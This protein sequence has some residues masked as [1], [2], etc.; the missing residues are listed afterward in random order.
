MNELKKVRKAF[1]LTQE[2]MAHLIGITTGMLKII[3]LGKRGP[4]NSSIH[5]S[6][7]Q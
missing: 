6:S 7:L 4:A 2:A 5:F 1:G 3:E